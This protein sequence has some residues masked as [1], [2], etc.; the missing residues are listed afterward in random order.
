MLYRSVLLLEAG[1][2]YPDRELLPEAVRNGGSTAGGDNGSPVSWSLRGALAEEQS[3]LLV[4]QGKV[5]GGSGSINGQVFLRGLPEDF[6][7]WASFGNEEWSYLKVLPYY[8]KAEHDM[9]IRDGLHGTDGP[10]LIVRREKETW[11]EIQAAFLAAAVQAGYRHNPDMN[12]PEPSGIGA[13]P[14]N[15]R[16][17]VRMSTAITH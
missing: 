4:A 12:G 8:R 5:I 13:I 9:D 11:P 6:E 3:D 16:D 2:D 14:M 7:R 17:G 10:L 1:Q 15:N